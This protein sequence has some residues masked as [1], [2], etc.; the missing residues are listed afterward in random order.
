MLA[1]I[2]TLLLPLLDPAL[3]ATQEENVLK[4]HC[5]ERNKVL[6]SSVQLQPESPDSDGL[7]AQL[8]FY[9]SELDKANDKLAEA[10]AE[11]QQ[12]RETLEY[13]EENN[14]RMQWKL[15]KAAED[16]DVFI[17]IPHQ[18]RFRLSDL[19]DVGDLKLSGILE[20]GDEFLVS[21]LCQGL[22][23]HTVEIALEAYLMK[24]FN[25]ISYIKIEFLGDYVTS[26]KQ[27]NS[28]GSR[29]LMSD[30]IEFKISQCCFYEMKFPHVMGNKDRLLK[31]EFDSMATFKDVR[32]KLLAQKHELEGPDSEC[33]AL[34][35][36]NRLFDKITLLPMDGTVPTDKLEEA[37]ELLNPSENC[38]SYTAISSYRAKYNIWGKEIIKYVVENGAETVFQHLNILKQDL[39]VLGQV[40]KI[41]RFPGVTSDAKVVVVLEPPVSE[42]LARLQVQT[43][44]A[45]EAVTIERSLVGL[46][47]SFLYFD[48]HPR[49][50]NLNEFIIPVNQKMNTLELRFGYGNLI[51]PQWPAYDTIG[52]IGGYEATIKKWTVNDNILSYEFRRHF[53]LGSREDIES[54]YSQIQL[55][56][57]YRKFNYCRYYEICKRIRWGVEKDWYVVY[58][59]E[60]CNP[61]VIVNGRVRPDVEKKII[62]VIE[63]WGPLNPL[64]MRGP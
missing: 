8:K 6:K 54:K 37:K 13:S 10:Q 47:D 57:D 58:I 18:Q 40:G 56:T 16:P 45:E 25:G 9:K 24:K 42:F 34:T 62:K 17:N 49:R 59:E 1:V 43:L 12:L 46:E 35:V 36:T 39:E 63:L 29:P 4:S 7:E 60:R 44:P 41:W 23:M 61:I 30:P 55:R 22:C 5:K 14:R 52:P 26:E 3:C 20:E 2:I 11:L 27:K 19:P 38:R 15:D 21:G 51:G 32:H 28:I 50:Q 48:Q 64:E 31:A 53:P 33:D